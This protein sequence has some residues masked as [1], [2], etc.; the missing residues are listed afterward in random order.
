MPGLRLI[1]AGLSLFAAASLAAEILRS[2]SQIVEQA[3]ATDWRSVEPENSL[4]IELEAG[5]VVVEL[6]PE[7]APAQAANFK[8]LVRE[9]FYDGLTIYRVVDGFVAQGG[10]VDSTRKIQRGKTP[11]GG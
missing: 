10:D 9:G 7:I 4:H 11:I 6:F 8:T 2:P 1:V 3:P 5:L